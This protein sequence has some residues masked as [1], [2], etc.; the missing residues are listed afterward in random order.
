MSAYTGANI[1][2]L[3]YTAILGYIVALGYVGTLRTLE[4]VVD[5]ACTRSVDLLISSYNNCK[6]KDNYA[7]T[8]YLDFL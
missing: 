6:S 7:I 4:Y 8:L 5:L 3:E 2:P 1:I